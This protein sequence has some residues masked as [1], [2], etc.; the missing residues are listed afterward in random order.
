[1]TKKKAAPRPR[2]R[3]GNS[4]RAKKA[5]G[6]TASFARKVSSFVRSRDS[7]KAPGLTDAV[8]E[9]LREASYRLGIPVQRLE[10]A[11]AA[12]RLES[13][14]FGVVETLVQL[15]QD[16]SYEERFEIAAKGISEALDRFAS[17]DEDPLTEVDETSEKEVLLGQIEAE[18]EVREL[19]RMILASCI[20]VEEAA[21]LA[22]RTRQR[23]EELRREGKL[24]AL[25]VKNRWRYPRWQFYPDFPGGVLP[26]L[27]EVLAHLQLSP[28]GSTA[29]LTKVFKVLGNHAPIELLRTGR[30]Q[31]VIE[32][33]E[34]HGHMP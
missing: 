29:W 9:F 27:G 5:S 16:K 21:R 24:L 14:A 13:E 2:M 33:A 25:R 17:S 1:M 23:L 20:G 26:G 7:A 12:A 10:V 34:E 8:T 19:R 6:H 3:K 4:K 18:L 30:T 22:E 32:L 15:N 11:V 28:A 31:E